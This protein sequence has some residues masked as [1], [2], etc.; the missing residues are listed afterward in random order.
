MLFEVL[1]LFV[2]ADEVVELQDGQGQE[3]LADEQVDETALFG[4]AP[5]ADADIPEL[6]AQI[7]EQVIQIHDG[8]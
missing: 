4:V 1:E 6:I 7:L 8:L 2:Q 3:T 5:P